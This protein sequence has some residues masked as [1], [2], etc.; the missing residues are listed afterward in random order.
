VPSQVHPVEGY[1]SFEEIYT[2]IHCCLKLAKG[3][4]FDLVK[5]EFNVSMFYVY[6]GF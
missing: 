1:S 3:S 6:S 2:R 4:A 5:Q